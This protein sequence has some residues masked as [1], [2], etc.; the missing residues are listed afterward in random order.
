[1]GAKSLHT[2][3]SSM[4]FLPTFLALGLAHYAVAPKFVGEEPLLIYVH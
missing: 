3:N 1:M 2:V 4:P